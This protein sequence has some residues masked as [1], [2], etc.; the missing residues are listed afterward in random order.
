MG[1]WGE[2]TTRRY[3]NFYILVG[4]TVEI[5]LNYEKT[6]SYIWTDNLFNLDGQMFLSINSLCESLLILC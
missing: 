6:T 1:G 5:N 4:I 3:V 2:E